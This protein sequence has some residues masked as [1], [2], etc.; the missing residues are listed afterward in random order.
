MTCRMHP[1]VSLSSLH[2]CHSELLFQF[3][4]LNG[5]EIVC[6]L[7]CWCIEQLVMWSDLDHQSLMA[8]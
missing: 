5:V 1:H 8:R 6:A 2:Y 3:G 7:A 4:Q